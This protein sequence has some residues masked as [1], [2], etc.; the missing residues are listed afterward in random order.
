MKQNLTIQEYELPVTINRDTSG[1]FS[2]SCNA[3]A[4]C[5]AQ[6]DSLEEVINEISYVAGSLIELYKEEGMSVPLKLKNTK[7]QSL[8]SFR[9]TFPLIVTGTS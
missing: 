9:L 2:A 3:W 6:G 8:P 1:G 5:Y 4:D 7:K